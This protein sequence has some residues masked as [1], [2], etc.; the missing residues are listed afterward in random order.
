MGSPGNSIR[1]RAAI[2]CGDHQSAPGR[3]VRRAFLLPFSLIVYVWLA[4]SAAE[5]GGVLANRERR[6]F[7][8][9]HHADLREHMGEVR[10]DGAAAHEQAGGDLGVSGERNRRRRDLTPVTN[11]IEAT[12]PWTVP[13]AVTRMEETACAATAITCCIEEVHH[14]HRQRQEGRNP[15]GVG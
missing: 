8:S 6:E 7:G 11:A 5:S 2:C 13:R 15:I 10:L 14:G 3:S 12:P 4:A 9:V 1:N